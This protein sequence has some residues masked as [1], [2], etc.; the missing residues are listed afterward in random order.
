[1]LKA[2]KKGFCIYNPTYFKKFNVFKEVRVCILVWE[3]IHIVLKTRYL[4]SSDSY[5]APAQ[6][7]LDLPLE[8]SNRSTF[9]DNRPGKPRNQ[10]RPFCHRFQR[11]THSSRAWA[12]MRHPGS[13]MWPGLQCCC[14]WYCRPLCCFHTWG[15]SV[16]HSVQGCYEQVKQ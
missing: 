16:A 8:S 7:G 13:P 15:H 5:Q 4:F 6:P 9:K 10:L 11:R 12:R 3:Y 14:T 1:M 2:T